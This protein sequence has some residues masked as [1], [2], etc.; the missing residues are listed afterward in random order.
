[1]FDWFNAGQYKKERDDA[2]ERIVKLR[3]LLNKERSEHVRLKR[4]LGDALNERDELRNQPKEAEQPDM[5]DNREVFKIVFSQGRA[6]KHRFKINYPDEKSSIAVCT[7]KGWALPHQVVAAA[8][9]LAKGR[10]ELVYE[11]PYG[12]PE[13]KASA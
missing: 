4:E 11:D 3:E 9:R 2:E 1:M 7:A 8:E 13:K 12:L 5:A 10:L 6:K